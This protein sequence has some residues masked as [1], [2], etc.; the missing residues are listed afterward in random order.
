MTYN[1]TH[2]EDIEELFY[3]TIKD[4]TTKKRCEQ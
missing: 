2:T 3:T 4:H 1:L